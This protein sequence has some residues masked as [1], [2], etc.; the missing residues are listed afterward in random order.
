MTDLTNEE[1]IPDTGR[2]SPND[3]AI[4]VLAELDKFGFTDEEKVETLS[5]LNTLL[6][7]Q[8]TAKINELE[9]QI[10]HLKSLKTVS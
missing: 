3:M 10:A 8:R 9:L 4:G 7:A 5:G 1:T 2:F 6:L